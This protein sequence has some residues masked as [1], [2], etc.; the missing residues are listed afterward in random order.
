MTLLATGDRNEPRQDPNS[1]YPEPEVWDVVVVG[2][3]MGGSISSAILGRAGLFVLVLESGTA[4]EGQPLSQGRLTKFATRL[5]G[6]WAPERRWPYELQVEISGQATTRTRQ[7]RAPPPGHGP[8][9]SAA[10]YGAVLARLRRIDF[11]QDIRSISPF[12]EPVEKFGPLLPNSWPISF[13]SFRQY[14]ARAEAMLRVVG[15]QDPLDPDADSVLGDP[16]PLCPRD[17]HL[18]EDL[19]TSGLNPFRLPMGCD[20]RPGCSECQGVRCVRGCKG[21]GYSRALSPALKEHAAC[22][23]TGITV[24]RLRREESIIVVEAIGS[25]GVPVSLR[26]HRLIL[27]AGALNTPRILLRSA[28]LWP[29]ANTPDLLGAGLMFHL[30]DYFAVFDRRRGAVFGPRKTIGLRDYYEVGGL[31]YGEIQSVGGDVTPGWVSSYLREQASGAGF[32]WLGP[33]LAVSRLPAEL[34]ARWFRDAALYATILEDFPYACNRVLIGDDSSPTGGLEPI[35][36]RYALSTELKTRARRMREFVRDG[37]SPNRVIFLSQPNTLNLGHPTGTCRM[38][39]DPSSSV[40]DPRGRLWEQP[41][42]YVADASVMP[43]SGGT[44]PGL[45]VAGH[46]FRVAEVVM[47]DAG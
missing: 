45:T 46:A 9:G 38:G 3:G 16:P 25:G 23:R 29:G 30:S 39:N 10:Y 32:R 18:A 47:E 17:G 6:R 35:R 19:R 2:A 40:T 33:L 36:L 41:G 7:I 21:E 26:T 4:V 1:A 43:S 37:F 34:A 31:P 20:Y 8:G 13:D 14:Y 24:H 5:F 44:N 22:L 15:S 28:E 12:M 11:E 42:L 27:A